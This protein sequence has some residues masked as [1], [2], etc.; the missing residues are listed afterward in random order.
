M[1]L[2]DRS[3]IRASRTYSQALKDILQNNKLWTYLNRLRKV[4]KAR[5]DLLKADLL[6]L[7]QLVKRYPSAIGKATRKELG[8]PIAAVARG[9]IHLV[10]LQTLQKAAS[11]VLPAFALAELSMESKMAG[12]PRLLF[13]AKWYEQYIAKWNL[14]LSHRRPI[15]TVAIDQWEFSMNLC[16]VTAVVG[17]NTVIVAVAYSRSRCSGSAVMPL[18]FPL[19][20]AMALLG[21]ARVSW[22]P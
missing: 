18:R 9:E 3:S 17:R 12:R 4:T 21:V 5:F 6:Y 8:H 20:L 7:S 1:T 13:S 15:V 22:E 11:I 16:V 14:F 19:P 10:Q 2:R